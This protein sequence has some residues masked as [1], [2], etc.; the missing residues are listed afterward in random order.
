MPARVDLQAWLLVLQEAPLLLL[1]PL[2]LLVSLPPVQLAGQAAVLLLLLLLLAGQA[3]LLLQV[4]LLLL[5]MQAPLLLPLLPR[6]EG[7]LPGSVATLPLLAG[8]LAG[9]ASQLRQVLPLRQAELQ[10]G[11]L[12]AQAA[13][14]LQ[15]SRLLVGLRARQAS[16][17]PPVVPRPGRSAVAQLQSCLGLCQ[18][19][20]GAAV[21]PPANPLTAAPHRAK[22]TETWAV[23]P[24][25][26]A[27]LLSHQWRA[28]RWQPPGF[29]TEA[30]AWARHRP[31][32]Q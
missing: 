2:P 4:L 32:S 20:G 28:C 16:Q 21:A 24:L 1:L 3:V 22:A 18:S 10:A 27:A 30:P 17:L 11:P 13:T 5:A 29:R 23:Q 26:P 14:M 12:V 9:Q 19:K 15:L 31:P 6:L 7:L 25:L 8:L